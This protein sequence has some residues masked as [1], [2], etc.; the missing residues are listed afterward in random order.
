[1][2]KAVQTKIAVEPKI[3]PRLHIQE[4]NGVKY[5]ME[6]LSTITVIMLCEALDYFFI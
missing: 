1:M 6:I 5:T 2:Y 3:L 4:Q